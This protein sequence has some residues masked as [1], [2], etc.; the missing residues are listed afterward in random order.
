[1]VKFHKVLMLV[2]PSGGK[3]ICLRLEPS[4]RLLNVSQELGILLDLGRITGVRLLSMLDSL[5]FFSFRLDEK[6]T[7]QKL[8]QRCNTENIDHVFYLPLSVIASQQFE[9]LST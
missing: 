1:M 4:F 8:S 2:V 5:T 7:L 3:T 9:I 6:I